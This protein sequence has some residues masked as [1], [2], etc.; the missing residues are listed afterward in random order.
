MKQ[1]IKSIAN[2][3]GVPQD[4]ARAFIEGWDVTACPFNY[5]PFKQQWLDEWNAANK[6]T[7]EAS[8]EFNGR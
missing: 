5:D 4:G 1:F 7:W 2:A 6:S 3:N 8:C